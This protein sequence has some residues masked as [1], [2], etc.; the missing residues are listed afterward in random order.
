MST[1][2]KQNKCPDSCFPEVP[3]GS[4]RL[5]VCKKHESLHTATCIK[6][7]N[8]YE[9]GEPVEGKNAKIT[10]PTLSTCC[11]KCNGI[12]RDESSFGR[13]YGCLK[14][15]CECH[16]PFIPQEKDE[17]CGV[18]IQGQNPPMKTGHACF[19]K[20]PC[21]DH[22][23]DFPKEDWIT[24]FDDQF[25]VDS[26]YEMILSEEGDIKSFIQSQIEAETKRCLAAHSS[27]IPF[28]QER[29][30]KEGEES[31]YVQGYIN[32]RTDIREKDM[33]R[34]QGKVE[35]RERI[36]KDLQQICN[37]IKTDQGIG[38]VLGNYIS[39]LKL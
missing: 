23:I 9:P 37:K 31:G 3:P 26:F 19:N 30:F 2:S 39:K 34:E 11:E 38:R 32:G 20:K 15:D 29:A 4:T 13:D 35:E 7:D 1:K 17:I 12:I 33:A 27:Q 16:K 8:K 18:H 6:S 28:I 36:V 25:P 5:S 10:Q 14:D 21:P 24:E 22:S